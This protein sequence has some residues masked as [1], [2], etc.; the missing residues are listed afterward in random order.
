MQQDLDQQSNDANSAYLL[1]NIKSQVNNGQTLSSLTNED[2]TK[3]MTLEGDD[4]TSIV[5]NII[6]IIQC[7]YDKVVVFTC[8]TDGVEDIKNYKP[9]Y[10]R[11]NIKDS[12]ES[13]M[14][15]E[16]D[17]AQTNKRIRKKDVLNSKIDR[18]YLLTLKD[19]NTINVKLLA[20]GDFN[21]SSKHLISGIFCYEN[22]ELQKVYWTDGL[23]I[24][25][26]I[27]IVSDELITSEQKMDA[28]PK[29][30][31]NHKFYVVREKGN[32]KFM[33]GVIQ[34]CFT[35]YNKYGA[36]T[37]IVDMTPLYY[38]AEDNKGVPANQAV[39]CSFKIYLQNP[40][41]NF[42]YAKIYSIQR[43]SLEGPEVVKEVGIIKI[44]KEDGS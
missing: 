18:I 38:I 36:E 16:E 1:Y 13:Y 4:D 5:G 11:D 15:T 31:L 26:F 21:F 2:G 6:G 41:T 20:E 27:N 19:E 42:D 37:G 40:D 14:K 12:D 25:R 32:G 29:F 33:S 22:S 8:N 34:Y 23:N 7:G 28:K 35:Y 10:V 17:V 3:S 39:A 44:N 43:N 9:Y 24:L 30:K